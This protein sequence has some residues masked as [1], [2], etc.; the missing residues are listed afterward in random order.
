LTLIAALQFYHLTTLALPVDPDDINIFDRF[1]EIDRSAI[2]LAFCG[3]RFGDPISTEMFPPK[4]RLLS[5]H[6]VFLEE[7]IDSVNEAA[8]ANASSHP[9]VSM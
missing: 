7:L 5:P 8:F 6:D 1:R 4:L 9:L 2:F 3:R